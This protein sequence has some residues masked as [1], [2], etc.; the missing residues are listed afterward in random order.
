MKREAR[1]RKW[2]RRIQWC[3]DRIQALFWVGLAGLIIY[4]TNFFRQLWENEEISSLF[5]NLTLVCLGINVTIMMFV[6]VVLPLQ[7]KEPDIEKT[8]GLIPVMTIAGILL[9]IFLTLAVW[10]LWGFLSP[11]YIFVLT[12][13]YIFSLTF[14]PS[15][16]FGT[17]VFWII[18]ISVATI[19]HKLPHAGHEHSW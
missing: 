16:K 7:G 8:P 5:M 11:F 2:V 19:S 3:S 1:K 14:L 4:K 18:M 10:P 12:F 15:G 17:L 6:T 9:P 13:G